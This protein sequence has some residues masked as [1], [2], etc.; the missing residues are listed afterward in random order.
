VKWVYK[1][2]SPSIKSSLEFDSVISELLKIRGID[3]AKKAEKYLHPKLS[4]LPDI[5]LLPN[6]KKAAKQILKALKNKEKIVIY[7]DYDVDG[8]SSSAILFDFIYRKLKGNVTPYIPNR[9]DEGYGLNDKALE[10]IFDGGAKLLITVDCGI[11]DAKIVNKFAKKGLK[12][13]I[14]DHHSLPK[15]KM[16]FTDDVIVVHPSLPKSKY[17]NKAICAANVAWKIVLAMC[18]NI[19][20]DFD[21]NSYIDIVALATVCDVMPLLDENRIIV[22]F[23]LEK[24]KSTNNQGLANIL[25]RNNLDLAKL[26]AYHLGF[27]LGPRLNAAGRMEDA[28]IALRFLTSYDQNTVMALGDKLEILN[29]E[30]QALT[31]KYMQNAEIQ[32]FEQIGKGHK[33]LSIIGEEWSEGIIGLVAGKLSEKFHMP[34]ISISVQKN[35]ITGSAR[36][37]NGFNITEAISNF[38]EMLERFGGHSQAAGFSVKS[39]MLEKFTKALQ[40]FAN[41]TIDSKK[42]EKELSIDLILSEDYLNLDFANKLDTLKPFGYGN[43]APIFCVKNLK[44]TKV[45]KMGSQQQHIKIFTMT[46]KG[47]MIE[48]VAFNRPELA[49][50]A[51]KYEKIDIACTI[52]INQWNNQE[53]IQLNV[54]D[55]KKSSKIKNGK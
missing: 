45:V 13:I 24:M 40:T 28:L 32:A 17:P 14:S 54:K 11:R 44:A 3:N 33:L 29:R 25:L 55:I 8:I 10:S 18:D 39:G 15:G 50:L 35:S 20:V 26:D 19:K 38:Q 34:T 31:A 43:T 7:G 46:P 9:F 53:S 12:I 30:R 36:S 4:D 48:A 37:I 16:G 1:Q 51:I 23:G 5:Y 42:I 6:L 21:P 49:D 47:R 2:K 22:K 27:I 41:K 52:D